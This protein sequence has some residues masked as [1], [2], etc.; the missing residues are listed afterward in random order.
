MVHEANL[1]H[2]QAKNRCFCHFI[3]P[4]YCNELISGHE[5]MRMHFLSVLVRF[6]LGHG[7]VYLKM[8]FYDKFC[9]DRKRLK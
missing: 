1:L 6:F 5:Q 7:N 2:L 4:F 9:K 3:T 8:A